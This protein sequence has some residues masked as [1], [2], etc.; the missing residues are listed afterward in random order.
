MIVRKF[1]SWVQTASA[2]SRAEG[3]SILARVYLYSDL[4][5][6]DFDDAEVALTSL[7]DDPSPLVRRAM[8]EA[9]ASAGDAPHH[10]VATLAADQSDVSTPILARSPLLS[11][12]DRDRCRRGPGSHARARRPASHR[13]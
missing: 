1:L 11:D 8:A 13:V 12:A 4:S 9:F 2:G 7:L 10:I 5:E 3:A 6:Q